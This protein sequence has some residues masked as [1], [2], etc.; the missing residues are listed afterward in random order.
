MGRRTTLVDGDRG[1]RAISTHHEA[2]RSLGAGYARHIVSVLIATSV[3]AYGSFAPRT[4]APRQIFAAPRQARAVLS[5]F[6]PA[7]SFVQSSR[8]RTGRLVGQTDFLGPAGPAVFAGA[9]CAPRLAVSRNL[10]F[11]LLRLPLT[12]PIPGLAAVGAVSVG[13]NPGSRSRSSRKRL[14]FS[15]SRKCASVA[16]LTKL[17]AM[18]LAPAR[19]VRPMRCT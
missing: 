14:R 13:S 8:R 5:P 4:A 12:P 10:S 17:T 19:P 2:G 1:V 11:L 18:P 6:G 15:M 3:V 16:A 9:A 7:L